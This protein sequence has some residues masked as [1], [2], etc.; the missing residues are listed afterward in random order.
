MSGAFAARI[1]VAV[2]SGA[3]RS[4]PLF[5]RAAPTSAWVRLSS[6]ARG[7]RGARHE[8]SVGLDPADVRV[9]SRAVADPRAHVRPA[10]LVHL[11]EVERARLGPLAVRV[12]DHALAVHPAPADVAH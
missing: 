5:A 10:D 6:L 7:G 9:A 12:L 2:A 11:A 1:S 8:R 3:R 4:R